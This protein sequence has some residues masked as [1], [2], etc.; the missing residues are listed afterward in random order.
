MGIQDLLHRY[1]TTE[2]DVGFG[3]GL[4]THEV[5]DEPQL[6]YQCSTLVTYPVNPPTPPFPSLVKLVY[7]VWKVIW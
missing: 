5:D 2:E 7:I 4:E 3:L 6:S 1:F